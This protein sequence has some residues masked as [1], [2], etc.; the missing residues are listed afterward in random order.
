MAPNSL[1]KS[2]ILFILIAVVLNSSISYCQADF[3]WDVIIEPLD[4][5]KDELYS[6]TKL[7]IAE[8]W[9]SAQ[10]VI[11]SD[12]AESGVVLVK[13]IT[14]QNLFFQM[15]D[16]RWTYAYTI[17]FM[18]KDKKCRII[19]DN[20]YCDAARCGI[21]EWPHMP[22]SD[23]YPEEKGLKTTGVNEVRYLELMAKL[24]TDLQTIVNSYSDYVRKPLI[25]DAD[26]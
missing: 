14:V 17:K 24:K 21:H 6:K 12:D 18:M 13:G 3:K 22:V 16:H 19:I 15:N 2:K 23:K 9:K 20:V 25:E 1:T 8:M 26:W 5:T 10:D 4:N 11:Q 7:F